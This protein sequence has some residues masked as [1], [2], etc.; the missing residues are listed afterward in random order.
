[1]T[2]NEKS[3]MTDCLSLIMKA[4]SN[5]LMNALMNR[6]ALYR[7]GDYCSDQRSG[8]LGIFFRKSTSK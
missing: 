8:E 3:R 1:M 5:L 4:A 7:T 2:H 6:Q